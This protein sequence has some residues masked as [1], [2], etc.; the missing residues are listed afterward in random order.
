MIYLSGTSN[1]DVRRA[2]LT[3]DRLGLIVQPG[4]YGTLEV[5]HFTYW[6]ADNGCFSQG[7][8]FNA[9]AWLRWLDNLPRRGCLFAVAPDVLGDFEATL[10]RSAPYLPLLREMGFKAA[11][12]AQN[13]W[14]SGRVDWDSF[15]CLFVGGDDAFKMSDR[16]FRLAEEARARGKWAH[17]GRCNTKGRLRAATWQYDSADGTFV[18]FGPDNNLPI[19]LRWLSEPHLALGSEPIGVQP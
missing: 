12:V 13:G 18:A 8:S 10:E 15:D 9:E 4:S 17:M 1:A 2:A 7:E 14:D 5:A 3:C 19:L 6:A 11:F 16:A